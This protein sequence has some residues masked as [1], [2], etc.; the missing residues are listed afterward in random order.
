MRIYFVTCILC[1]SLGCSFAQNQA[2]NWFFGNFAGLDFSAGDPVPTNNGQTQFHPSINPPSSA[3]HNEGSSTISD[4]NGNLLFYSDGERLFNS[5]HQITPNGNDLL[6]NFSSTQSSIFVPDPINPN[7]SFYLFTVGSLW[8]CDIVPNAGLRYSK[9]DACLDDGNGDIITGEKNILLTTGV[10]EKIAVTRHANGVDYWILSHLYFT[11]TFVA[12]LLTA[13]GIQ[14]SVT[15]SIGSTHIMSSNNLQN[16]GSIGQLKFSNNG[17][18]VAIA[19]ANGLNLLELFD[20]DSSTG[21]VSNAVSIY[22]SNSF[23]AVYGVEFS[24]SNLILYAYVSGGPPFSSTEGRVIQYDISVFNA[25]AILASQTLLFTSNFLNGRGIQLGPDNRL[26]VPGINSTIHRINNPDV[27]GLGCNFQANAIQL[28]PGTQCSYTLPTFIAGFDYS[29]EVVDCPSNNPDFTFTLGPDIL[30]CPESSVTLNAPPNELSYLWNTGSTSS[31]INVNQPG[32]YWVTVTS[33]NGTAIDTIIVS[34][35]ASQNISIMGALGVCQGNTTDLSAS[36]GFSNFQWN[37]GEVTQNI[38]VGAGTYWLTA[39]DPNGCNVSDT[40]SILEFPNPT[41]SISGN[42]TVCEGNE[43]ILEANSGF[44]A[45]QWSNGSNEAITN[46]GVGTYSVTVTDSLGCQATS[47]ITVISSSP[48]AGIL[49]NS[50][51]IITENQLSLQSTSTAGLFPINS[52]NW[53]FGDGNT[54]DIENPSH[55]YSEAGNYI[56]TLV[57]TDELGCADTTSILIVVVGDIFIP[58]V[59]TPNS[60]NT[61]DIFLIQ[62]L[63]IT[64]PSKLIVLNRWG[65]VVFEIENYQNDWSP[66]NLIDGV[67]FYQFDYT[68]KQYH[69]FFHVF[70]GE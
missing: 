64:L 37:T 16:A 44:V 57:V 11:N 49:L 59:V 12:Y 42:T 13:D 65:N 47:E 46:V 17:Q 4:F 61:N 21:L 1:M 32:T 66:I 48:S 5:Q 24:P 3:T 68:N 9:I 27:L 60:D 29:N 62:N 22:P 28:L 6:G 8:C 39:N 63:D 58:N 51:V 34:N 41:V 70:G 20:F 38:T 26:Y 18:K 23:Y 30:I 67:Y 10:S 2:N 52:W 33:T 40:I 69:G 14:S 50:D 43:T 7:Q 55:S 36:N 54:S 35:F 25:N 56:I 45:Y 15:S 19:A 31:S 53:S